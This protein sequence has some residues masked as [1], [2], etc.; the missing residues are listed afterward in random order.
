M[1]ICFTVPG[2][3]QGKGRPR[4]GRVGNHARMF[5]PE[6]TVNY[7]NLVKVK[8]EEA[9]GGRP[10]FQGPCKVVI[11]VFLQVPASWSKKKR[12]AALAG[13]IHPTTKPDLDNVVKVLFDGMNEV[14]WRD[15]V[16]VVDLKTTKRY[17][18]TPGLVV[19]VEERA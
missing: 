3:P 13:D 5:T 15:D 4:I 14:V 6:K 19:G 10:L 12:E 11:G 1:N 9:M 7:E 17:S 8:A 18:L 2:Q 16:Q